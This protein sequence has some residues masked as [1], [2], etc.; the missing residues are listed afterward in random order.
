M[1][2]AA[3]VEAVEKR[4][5]IRPREEWVLL[6]K[7]IR[8]EEMVDGVIRPEAKDERSQRGQVVSVPSRI[9]DLHPG[10]IVIFTNFPI[11]LPD[12]EDLTGDKNLCLVRG[13]EIFAVA[14]SD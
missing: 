12:L 1:S 11:E 14:E 13:E 10:D 3:T 7:L 4:F 5:T 2:K 8:G 9:L 6:R